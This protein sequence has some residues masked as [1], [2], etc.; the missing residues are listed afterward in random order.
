MAENVRSFHGPLSERV[1]HQTVVCCRS[2]SGRLLDVGCGNGLLFE[3]L[4]SSTALRCFGADR[5]VELLTDVLHRF[6]N[7]VGCA[8]GLLD[9]LPFR[10]RAF[11]VVTCLNT[12]LNLPSFDSVTVAL[13]E[14]MRVSAGRVIV[15]IRNAG[16][17]YLRARY[18]W[19]RRH[20]TFPTIAYRSRDIAGVFESGGF[21]VEHAYPI[22]MAN[23]WLAWGY[24]VVAVRKA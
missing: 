2:L 21:T 7:R 11:D 18:W 19:H 23:E 24:V 3:E 5:S 9:H 1:R 17:P 6:D 14:M 22:G 16:N 15:D 20:A 4:A 13:H 12:L 10:D 8:N